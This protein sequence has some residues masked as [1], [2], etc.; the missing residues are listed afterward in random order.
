M[1]GRA[2]VYAPQV[3][4]QDHP[5][6]GVHLH[7]LLNQAAIHGIQI[8]MS[9]QIL[10]QHIGGCGKHLPFSGAKPPLTDTKGS[11]DSIEDNLHGLISADLVVGNGATLHT[12]FL[13]KLLLRQAQ[14]FSELLQSV[15][16][17]GHLNLQME[18]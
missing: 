18:Y 11:T 9:T 10:K 4:F 2:D 3:G 6:I 8:I 12:N 13:G 7:V 5:V 16:Q 1:Q 17:S 15:F 14:G